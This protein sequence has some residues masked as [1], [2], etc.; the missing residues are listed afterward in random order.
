MKSLKLLF[1]AAIAGSTAFAQ[2]A[3]IDFEPNG[4]GANWTWTV[5]ENDTNP[6][7]EIIANP[8][9]TGANTSSTVA[10]FTA[11]TGGQPW[12]GFESQHGTDIGSF[13][14]DSST[15]TITIKVWKSVISDVG[16]KLVEANSASLGEIKVA[17]TVTGEWE[18]LTFDF[19][20]AE[21][22]EYDQIVIFPDFDLAGRTTDNECYIDDVV[23]GELAP[24]PMPMSPAPDPVTPEEYVISLFSDVYTDEAVDTWLTSWS[25]ASGD[26]IDISGNA[27][28]RYLSLDFAGVEMVGDNSID[29]TEMDTF[30]LNMWTP[31]ASQFRVKLVDFGAD[32]AFGGGDDTEHEL[33]FDTPAQETWIDYN[34][35]LESFTGLTGRSHISQLIIAGMPTGDAQVYLDNVYFSQELPVVDDTT[36]AIAELAAPI[37][38]I[39]PN[40]AN[41]TLNVTADQSVS[42]LIMLD[43]EGRVV[44]EALPSEEN[45]Q[46]DI[47]HL[48]NG[49]YIL[50]LNVNGQRSSYKLL[51]Q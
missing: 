3:P 41:H 11:L 33:T 6:P 24:L 50:Q 29:I 7:V 30:H 31:N 45:V 39:F 20:I 34:L 46:L 13:T 42:R 47:S 23:F 9:P 16:I 17:N 14:L 26:E 51:K 21:G 48:S 38:S 27:T 5:F 22:I 25:A 12:A 49:H 18:E 28:K 35:P 1:A 32:N 19:S 2:N 40:P 10:K 43:M 8:D 37:V 15:S 44:L 4:H 36:T